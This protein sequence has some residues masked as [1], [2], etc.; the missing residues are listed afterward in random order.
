MVE[1]M[2]PVPPL[3]Y[4]LPNPPLMMVGRE[5]ELG[6]IRLLLERGPLAIVC[7]PG[8]L[9]KSSLVQYALPQ[10]PGFIRENTLWIEVRPGHPAEDLRLQLIR[11]L[12][13]AQ[14]IERMDWANVV[15]DDDTALGTLL[16][17]AESGQWWV[18][19]DDLHHN[20]TPMATALLEQLAR[21]ARHSRW[22]V[23]SREIP[24][25]SLIRPAVLVLSSLPD[26][27]LRRLGPPGE[28]Q[29]DVH[30]RPGIRRPCASLRGTGYTSAVFF[31]LHFS[32]ASRHAESESFRPAL[33]RWE[34]F[35]AHHLSCF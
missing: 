24:P 27:A 29:V 26:E 30:V 2:R 12:A 17:L 28:L 19:L 35:N 31:L 6:A 22:I 13:R 15:S 16:D 9:G 18:V 4:R 11:I 21:Y 20:Q 10:T 34:S 25:S 3:R 14:G 8:G 32:A 23:T 5:Q 7:G 33:L 1:P